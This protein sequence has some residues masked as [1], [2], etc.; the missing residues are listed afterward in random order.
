MKIFLGLKP[1]AS[2]T[3]IEKAVRNLVTTALRAREASAES[4]V[5]GED[6]FESETEWAVQEELEFLHEKE[7]ES[8]NEEEQEL[9]DEK[10]SEKGEV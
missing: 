10:K 7:R 3:D 5:G 1:E 8:Q 9:R 2:E 4:E 6:D